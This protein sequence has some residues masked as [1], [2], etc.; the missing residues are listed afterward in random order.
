MHTLRHFTL[1]IFFSVVWSSAFIAGKIALIDVDPFILL[2]LRFL[3]SAAIL[4]PFCLSRPASLFARRNVING[5]LLGILNNAIYLGL[6]FQALQFIRPSLVVVIVSCAPFA[7]M[8]LATL[9]G[10]ERIGA[11][12]AAGILSGVAGVVV[13]AGWHPV[14]TCDLTG[15]GLAAAGTLAF[16]AGTVAFHDR[17]RGLRIRDVNFWQSV[18]GIAALL[19]AAA[20]LEHAPTH[21]SRASLAAIVWLALV[22][23]IG[24]MALWFWLIRTD[25]ASVAASWHL[26]NP[27]CGV[28]LSYLLLDGALKPG[29]FI[30]AGMVAI[31]LLLTSA[32]RRPG[33]KA[34]HDATDR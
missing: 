7:T 2:S 23:T 24:G 1:A 34:P 10:Q 19:P 25:G 22:V 14:T 30:G 32:R 21:L 15:I 27:F 31:G 26:M 33:M 9:F 3:L 11:I 29:D 28:F 16:A 20:L 5:C 6:T 18:A 17:A 13:I 4:L 12:R 8:L